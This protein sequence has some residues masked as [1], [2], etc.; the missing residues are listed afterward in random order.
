LIIGII[1][2]IWVVADVVHRVTTMTNVIDGG[3]VDTDYDA[4]LRKAKRRALAVSL[5]G[6]G[7]VVVG[8]VLVWLG[9]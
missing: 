6:P 4:E 3:T 7:L 9:D 1:G 5:P 2:A 8:A